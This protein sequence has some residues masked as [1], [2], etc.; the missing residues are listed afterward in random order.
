MAKKKKKK[1]LMVF[2][3]ALKIFS[4][5]YIIKIKLPLVS[6]TIPGFNLPFL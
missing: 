1:N 6:P 2:F 4:L 3:K 5:L